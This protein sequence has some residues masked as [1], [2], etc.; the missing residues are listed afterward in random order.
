[1]H[2]KILLTCIALLGAFCAAAIAQTPNSPPPT[3]IDNITETIHGVTITDPYRWLED[4]NSPQTR[5]WI[6][7]EN[8][9]TQSVISTVPGRD[10]I[11]QQVEKLLKVDT[12]SPPSERGGRYFFTARRGDQA[13]AVMYVRQG[14]N[15]KD[16]VLL[17]PNSMSADHTVSVAPLGISRDGRMMAYGVRQGGE[18]EVTVHFLNIDTRKD[19]SD[20]MPRA[21]YSGMA[22]KLDRSGLY[23]SKFTSGLP[24]LYYHAMGSES[25][26][27]PKILGDSL[28]PS[29]FIGPSVSRD[30][31]YL[32]ITIGHG[33]SED[34]VK[35]YIK[36][37]QS[38]GPIIPIVDDIPARFQGTVESGH[39]YMFTNWQAPNGRIID[40]E[41]SNPGRD[42]WKVVVPEGRSPLETYSLVG[43]KLFVSYLDNASTKIEVLDIAGKHVREIQFPM[44]G[45]ASPMSGRW[46]SDEGFYEFQS[47]AQPPTIYRYQVSTGKQEVWAKIE[48]PVPTGQIEVK[49]VWYESKDKTRVPMFLVYKRGIKLDGNNPVYLT[50]YG[51]FNVN[52]TPGYSPLA[53]LWAENGGVFAQPNMRGGG[54]FG[55]E[56]HRAGMLQNKQNVF[57][58]FNSAAEWLIANKYTR[59]AR[60]SIAGGSNGGL[61]VGAALTQRPDLYQAVVCS[62]PLLDMIRYQDF[63][64]AKF[65]VP[66]YGS[67]ED[68]KQ[69]EYI[70]KYS[71]YHNVK[72]G[73][74]YPAVLL[75]SGD[76]DTRVAPLHARKMAALLQASTGS[77]R[78]VLL[79]YD[80][81]AGHS[82]GLPL[83]KRIDNLT[84]ELCFLFWQL[85]M[86]AAAA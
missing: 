78:P 84:D 4:Q 65:W 12:I 23:Y 59:P 15:G 79:H 10:Q 46:D 41:L 58:D 43:G 47:F 13:Q 60:L 34:N 32:T 52:L 53:M 14:L 11:H 82:G 86:H 9:Y 1:M 44:I 49:Q 83:S 63:L 77:D 28:G 56:W 42:H 6:D 22:I 2:S 7:S 61:L 64:V 74:K 17:D 72:K 5:A 19:L 8:Q 66:E 18:D 73:T 40:I 50:G 20:I 36:D 67:S 48:A 21:R 45:S 16:E 25:A 31:R 85:G 3:K 70:L 71:P 29:D 57:D 38:D 37:L 26:S 69:F 62:F 54:E 81:K 55:E 35:I 51:G 76:F 39:L 80:T 30:G 24:G 33:S 75:I 27:D 68:P